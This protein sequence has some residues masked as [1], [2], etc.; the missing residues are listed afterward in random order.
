M[1]SYYFFSHHLF[2]SN[3]SII[4]RKQIKDA[5][6]ELDYL[7]NHLSGDTVQ[8]TSTCLRQNTSSTIIIKNYNKNYKDLF[9]YSAGI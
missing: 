5:L 2:V 9:K 6:D 3:R 1:S 4:Y 8:I 7:S